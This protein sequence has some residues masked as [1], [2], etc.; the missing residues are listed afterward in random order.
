[1][2]VSKDTNAIGYVG[3]AHSGKGSGVKKLTVNGVPC[4]AAHIKNETLSAVPLRSGRCCRPPG[5][6]RQV[7][8]FLD[9]VRTS[10]GAGKIIGKSGAVPAFNKR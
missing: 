1:M 6:S 5:P 7:E 10:K 9:W 4:D 3:L 8:N 2:A